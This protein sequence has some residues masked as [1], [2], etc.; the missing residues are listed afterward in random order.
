M[1][2]KVI[3]PEIPIIMEA[4]VLCM[5]EC[6]IQTTISSNLRSW[7]IAESSGIWQGD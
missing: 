6:S 3:S 7:N 4:D 2:V 5:T 1:E